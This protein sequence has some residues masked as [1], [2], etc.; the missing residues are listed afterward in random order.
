MA[1]QDW[2]T[3]ATAPAPSPY[4]NVVVAPSQGPPAYELRPLTLGEL[5]DRT[6][7]LYRSRFWLFSGISA[8]AAAVELVIAG[9]GRVIMHHYTKNPQVIYTAGIFVTWIAYI[10]YFFFYCVTQ[11]ATCFA[12]AEVYLN[13]P[14]SI[15]SSLRAV[16]SKWYAWVGIALW[17]GWS[18]GWPFF[19]LF[20]PFIILTTLKVAFNTAVAL[21]IFLG[22]L[23][24]IGAAVYG[25]IAYI[26]NSLAIPVKVVEGLSV[27]KAMRR[28]KDLED[29]AKGRTFVLGL[30]VWALFFVAGVLQAPFAMM[31]VLAPGSSHV[32]SE[33]A[34]LLI[35]FLARALVSPVASIGLC[36]IYFDQRV[37]REAFDLEVLLGPEQANALPTSP[38]SEPY[39]EPSTAPDTEAEANG[40]LL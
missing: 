32:L 3:P 25:V 15:G 10:I 1:E 33:I 29:G 24:V 13:R 6:F 26:R 2:L 7:S 23:A 28:S 8:S 39:S 17:Q 5:L 12:M 21:L 37:R 34:T 14:A 18:A 36:L 4:S 9:A 31:T 38:V 35:M 27:R 16:R 22:V 40:P 20:V 19:A 30:I 11:A